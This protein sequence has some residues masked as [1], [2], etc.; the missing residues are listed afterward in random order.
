MKTNC[1]FCN[2]EF[3]RI[4]SQ[5]KRSSNHFCSRSCAASFNNSLSPKRSLEGTCLICKTKISKRLKYCSLKCRESNRDKVDPKEKLERNKKAVVSYRQRMKQKAIEYKG[6][7]CKLCGY[8]GPARSMHF[9]HLDPL[10]KDFAISSVTRSWDRVKIEL[11]KC[12]LLC[13]RCHCEV[14][15][16][17][18]SL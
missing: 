12:V 16:G 17:L 10:K 9:H 8:I 6:P 15:G 4:P 2:I 13:C 3:E 5:L 11:D 14:H 18:V 7:F 1:S